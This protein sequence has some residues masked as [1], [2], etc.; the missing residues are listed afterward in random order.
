MDASVE[1]IRAMM[2]TLKTSATVTALVGQRVWDRVPD[3]DVVYP[4]ISLGPTSSIPDDFD[5]RYGEEI[6]VQ[7]D[8]WSSGHGE[9]HA[10]VECRK[11]ADAVKR[12]L[13]EAE[14]SLSENA[15]V[16]LNWDLTRILDDPDPAINHGV[17]QFTA[18]VETP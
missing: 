12:A 2:D 9:A 14:L 16:T 4:Y 11:I 17:L 3:R 5:C 8:V 7:F 6:S 18:T 13:H 10:S 15:L 1:L